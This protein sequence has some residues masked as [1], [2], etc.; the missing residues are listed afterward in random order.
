VFFEGAV[1]SLA[2]SEELADRDE[3]TRAVTRIPYYFYPGETIGRAGRNIR[4]Y[5]SDVSDLTAVYIQRGSEQITINL[6][7]FLYQ[8]EM[9]GDIPLES[10]DVIVIPYRQ[11][12]TI[13]GEVLTAGNRPI[14]SLVR[15]SSLLT[16][17]TA[18]ASTRMVT[19]TSGAGEPVTYDLYQSRR[20]GDLSQDPYIRP[21]DKIQVL[22]AGRRV[23]I[24][25]EVFRPGTYELL[26]GEELGSL[27]E[28][29]A[30]GFTLAA[31]PGRVRLS[32]IRTEAAGETRVFNYAEHTGMIL[33]D[34]DVITIGNKAAGRPIA[35][36]RGAISQVTRGVEEIATEGETV[37]VEGMAQMEYPFYE[38]ETLGSAV[39]MNAARF[40]VSSDLANAY[41]RR[42]N[43]QIPMDLSRYIYYNDFSKDMALENGDII[44]IP[45][46]QYF[47]L[48]TGAV[49]A[50]GRYPYVPDREAEY[51]IN[52]AGGRDEMKNSGKGETVLDKNNRKVQE[53]ALIEPEMMITVP[54][55]R[56]LT[57]FNEVAPVITTVL[58]IITT[59]LSLMAI[60][61]AF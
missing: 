42:G 50:P 17:L 28:R 37:S 24:T 2:E 6:E 27:V 4:S 22:P 20:F 11:F 18:K 60:S 44:I 54:A 19:V 59:F 5:F 13:T 36:F 1:F 40:T 33:E 41:V 29:Y 38:G 45:F 49:K 48:V 52:L 58:S 34:R 9:T 12:Y 43:Q 21:G 55:N 46:Q 53:A 7:R 61:G 16:D 25:G 26:P 31:D 51:Y 57:K 8:N 30:D 32:R 35:F 56:F 10:G 15:L 14:N 39:R 47:V 23:S 3:R